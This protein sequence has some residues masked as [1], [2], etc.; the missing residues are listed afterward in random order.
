MEWVFLILYKILKR[1]PNKKP[2]PVAG[3]FIC[4]RMGNF[5]YSAI[6]GTKDISFNIKLTTKDTLCSDFI[7]YPP[8]IV[9][10]PISNVVRKRFV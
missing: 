8:P 7:P 3:F 1:I 9:V 5:E 6:F 4:G 10:N 2:R